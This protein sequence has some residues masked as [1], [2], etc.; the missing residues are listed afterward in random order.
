MQ[1]VDDEFCWINLIKTFTNEKKTSK[2]FIL[3]NW[4]VVQ[5][6]NYNLNGIIEKNHEVA[7]THLPT[8]NQYFCQKCKG[9][10][11]LAHKRSNLQSNEHKIIRNVVIWDM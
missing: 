3:Y 2:F 1:H 4:S 5:L 8:N 11:N 6:V 9:I 7:N 10:I